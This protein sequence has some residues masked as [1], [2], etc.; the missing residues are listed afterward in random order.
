MISKPEVLEHGCL[1]LFRQGLAYLP[2][3]ILT[4]LYQSFPMKTHKPKLPALFLKE[5]RM[6]VTHSQN[7]YI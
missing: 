4:V 3:D 6:A 5:S 7:Q 2:R 1:C